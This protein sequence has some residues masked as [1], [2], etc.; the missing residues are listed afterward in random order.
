MKDNK[1]YEKRLNEAMENIKL[2]IDKYIKNPEYKKRLFQL[3]NILKKN[4]D[5]PKFTPDSIINVVS[6]KAAAAF[7]SYLLHIK[8][9]TIVASLKN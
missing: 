1:A 7:L 3:D 5:N 9:T 6:S 4:N 8:N 2:N